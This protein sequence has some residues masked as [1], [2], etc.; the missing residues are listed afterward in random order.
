MVFQP[1]DTYP[2]RKYNAE[3]KQAK[4]CTSKF[5]HTKQKQG[6]KTQGKKV[7]IEKLFLN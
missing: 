5:T 6:V 1:Y 2:N 3:I 4:K 7:N